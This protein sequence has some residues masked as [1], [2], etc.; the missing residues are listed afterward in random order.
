M[1]RFVDDIILLAEKK[2]ELGEI[3]NCMDD[4]LRRSYN[5]KTRPLRILRELAGAFVPD[6]ERV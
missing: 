2:K 6:T 1:P 3:L 5:M 4:I